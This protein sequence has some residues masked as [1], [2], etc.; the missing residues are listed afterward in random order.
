MNERLAAIA[1]REALHCWHGAVMGAAST[2]RPIA[3]LFPGETDHIGGWE[4]VW[5]AA[6]VYYCVR[7]AGFDLPPRW[8]DPR[9][10]C[11]FAGCVAWEEWA[12]LPWVDRWHDAKCPPERGDLVLFDRVDKGEEHDHMG[13]VLG[14]EP[15]L[16]RTAEGNFGNVSA[17]VTR[18]L[19][20]H[21]RGYVRM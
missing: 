16:L 13:V 17:V 6:F 5:C 4:H 15:G 7:Q 14:A 18:P 10:S 12:R 11:S 9:V 2:L 3:E 21:I 1:E 8:P 19:D 20:G